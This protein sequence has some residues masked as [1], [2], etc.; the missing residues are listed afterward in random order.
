MTSKDD[1]FLVKMFKSIWYI[2]VL[3]IAL[4]SASVIL[5]GIEGNNE[6]LVGWKALSEQEIFNKTLINVWFYSFKKLIM[7]LI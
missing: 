7:S 5:M 6:E 4:L 2:V 3:A 1:G